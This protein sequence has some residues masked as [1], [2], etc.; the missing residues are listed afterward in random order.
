MA[1]TPSHYE[2]LEIPETASEQDIKKAYR[3]LSIIYHPDK[4]GGNAEKFRQI[5]EAYHVLYDPQ[6][7]RAYDM[8]RQFAKSGGVGGMP[9]GMT[10]N[11]GGMGGMGGIPGMPAGVPEVIFNMMRGMG[12]MGGVGGG[13]GDDGD[14]GR[15]QQFQFHFVNGRPVG[16]GGVGGGGGIPGVNIFGGDF[17]AFASNANAHIRRFMVPQPIVKQVELNMAQSYTGHTAPIEIERIIINEAGERSTE[18]DTIYVS[19]PEGIDHNEHIIV[20]EKGHINADKKGDIK[21]QI[22]LN[23]DSVYR[24]EGLDLIYKKRISLKEALCGFKFELVGLDQKR[25]LIHNDGGKIIAPGYRKEIP[26]LGM[27]REGRRGNMHIVFEVEFPRELTPQQVEK[28][29]EILE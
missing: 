10:F 23:N 26:E 9:R 29:G 22:M 21:I 16:G 1:S 25:Y 2:I 18:K 13:G 20:K 6:T 15:P 5:N 7:R 19:I 28:L 4:P 14:D 12:G 17:G 24:R 11:M 3:R 27:K 8:E